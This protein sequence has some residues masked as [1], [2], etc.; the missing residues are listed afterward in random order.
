L[1]IRMAYDLATLYELDL[2][3]WAEVNVAGSQ[4]RWER[5]ILNARN[6]IGDILA[7]SPS[8]APELP[9]YIERVYRAA[10]KLAAV[11]SGRDVSR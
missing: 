10:R 1:Q 5:S 3:A 8:L 2:C 6:E 11:E 9:E 7:E 4:C